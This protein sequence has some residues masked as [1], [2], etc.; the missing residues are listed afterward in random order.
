MDYKRFKYNFKFICKLLSIGI[1][2]MQTFGLLALVW[3]TAYFGPSM[4]VVVTINDYGE[5]VPELIMWI[6]ITPICLY[7]AYLNIQELLSN[8][9]RMRRMYKY[10]KDEYL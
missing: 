9:T 10:M 5:A 4:A 3:F 2:L 6:I 7:G 8:D 1:P